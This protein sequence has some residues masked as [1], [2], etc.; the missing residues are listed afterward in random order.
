MRRGLPEGCVSREVLIDHQSCCCCFFFFFFLSQK[1]LCD[2]DDEACRKVLSC[3]PKKKSKQATRKDLF[4]CLIYFCNKEYFS[5]P[6]SYKISLFVKLC[7]CFVSFVAEL[8][9]KSFSEDCCI[10]IECHG[11]AK[12]LVQDFGCLC[13]SS[14]CS[15]VTQAV[16]EICF[17]F[18]FSSSAH[19]RD[20]QHLIT[21]SEIA[22]IR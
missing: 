10:I 16:A 12:T 19:K 22:T 4:L 13:F 17:F 21:V 11:H 7:C 15:S 20:S 6:S 14:F 2:D 9:L 8:F 5:F 1:S 3:N 18:F